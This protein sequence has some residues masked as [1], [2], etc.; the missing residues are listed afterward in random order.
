MQITIGNINYEAH[1]DCG[2]G[3]DGCVADGKVQLC[4]TLQQAAGDEISYCSDYQVIWVKASTNT[5][6][7]AAVE[8]QIT[9][10]KPGDAVQ[11]ALNNYAELARAVQQAG[12]SVH[13]VLQEFTVPQLLETLAINNITL[14]A[15]YAKN[16]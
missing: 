6:Q 4:A 10:T 7:P 14:K 13:V 11:L 5:Q 16:P 3:C 9:A 15:T 12:G 8:G 2:N 1:D